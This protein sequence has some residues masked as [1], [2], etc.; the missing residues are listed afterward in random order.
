MGVSPRARSGLLVERGRLGRMRLGRRWA[1]V[2]AL[3][4][5]RSCSVFRR[6]GRAE[7]LLEEEEAEAGATTSRGRSGGLEAGTRLGTQ[8]LAGSCGDG[9]ELSRA[10]EELQGHGRGTNSEKSR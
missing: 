5:E 10:A 3:E 6:A 4:N 9:D 8:G 1:L 7:L 2:N